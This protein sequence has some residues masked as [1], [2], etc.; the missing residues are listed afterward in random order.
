MRFVKE[1]FIAGRVFYNI[2]DLNESALEWCNK[3]NGVY[4][5]AVDCIPAEEHFFACAK[6]ARGIEKTQEVAMYLCPC[7]TISFDGFVCYE[8][9]RFGVPYWYTEHKCRVKREGSTLYIYSLDLSKLL[10]KHPVT[11]SKR[12]CFCQDQYFEHQPVEVPSVPVK[13]VIQQAVPTKRS[14]GFSKFH[15]DE[16][17]DE[18]A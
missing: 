9:R 8:G 2:T 17:S 10:V 11:W 7:R 6:V 13:A 4:H 5:K 18:N 16:E 1:N 14:S 3:Q 15:F 12:D